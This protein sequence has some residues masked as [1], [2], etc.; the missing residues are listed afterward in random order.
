MKT[1]YLALACAMSIATGSAA[2]AV[3]KWVDERGVTQYGDVVPEKYA[4]KSKKADVIN[5]NPTSL[6]QSAAQRR[7]AQDQREVD[8]LEATP[9]SSSIKNDNKTAGNASDCQR[10]WDIYASSTACFSRYRLPNG[11]LRSGASNC[12]EVPAPT[13]RR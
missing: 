7:R 13:C 2:G 6:D 3:Y 11:N 5:T 12:P 10:Q 1:R 9:K 4:E 8:R